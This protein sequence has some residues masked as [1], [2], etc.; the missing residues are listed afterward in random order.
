MARFALPL[1]VAFGALGPACGPAEPDLADF[2]VVDLER[3]REIAVD[4]GR[5][6]LVVFR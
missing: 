4:S 1:A 5:P 2:W 6:M 3:A